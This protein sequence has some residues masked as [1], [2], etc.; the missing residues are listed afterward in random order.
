MT[1]S[2]ETHRRAVHCP[3][4]RRDLTDGPIATTLPVFALP[5]FG[6]KVLQS[7]LVFSARKVRARS[8]AGG[9]LPFVAASLRFFPS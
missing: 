6:T 9:E 7:T 1:H 3:M 5:I 8:Y 2:R 4:Q